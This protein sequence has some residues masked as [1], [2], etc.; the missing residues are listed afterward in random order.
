[1]LNVLTANHTYNDSNSSKPMLRCNAN[2]NAHSN[3]QQQQQQQQQGRRRA[4]RL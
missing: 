2:T 4:T 1:V 3:K